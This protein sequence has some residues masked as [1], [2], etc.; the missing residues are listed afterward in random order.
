MERKIFRINRNAAFILYNLIINE[1]VI[2]IFYLELIFLRCKLIL[3]RLCSTL[4][5]LEH[6][7]NH[8][9]YEFAKFKLKTSRENKATSL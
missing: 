3:A 7:C 2:V 8:Y 6:K 1:I 4:L 5:Y 9:V